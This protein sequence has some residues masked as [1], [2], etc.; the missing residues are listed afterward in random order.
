T[1]AITELA[2]RSSGLWPA[3]AA[4]LGDVG[5]T[6][7]GSLVLAF[8]DETSPSSDAEWVD[9]DACLALEPG[10]APDCIGAWHLPCDAQV[11]PRRVV[12]RLVE[13]VGDAL[14]T[15]ADVVD[16]T[17]DGVELADGT[18]IVSDRVVLA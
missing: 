2:R 3:F 7:C 8:G 18:R 13:R 14:R 15:G 11:D 4:E 10:V 12:D 16:V 17:P 9:R 5:Y 6:R 1:E